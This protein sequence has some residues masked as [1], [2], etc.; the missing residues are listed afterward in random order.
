MA[1]EKTQADRFSFVNSSRNQTGSAEVEKKR[2][3]DMFATFFLRRLALYP[4]FQAPLRKGGV[5]ICLIIILI[6]SCLPS[7]FQ[8]TGG[9][10]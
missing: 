6:L 7:S 2:G 3:F 5:F 4:H 9:H 1:G 8:V 10:F